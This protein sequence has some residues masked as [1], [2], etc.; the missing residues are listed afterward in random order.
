MAAVSAPEVRAE[1]PVI[2]AIQARFAIGGAADVG[3]G[4]DRTNPRRFAQGR[5]EQGRR[6]LFFVL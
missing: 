5:P 3:S 4:L 2:L 1:P 6:G